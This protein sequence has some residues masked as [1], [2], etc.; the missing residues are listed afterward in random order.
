MVRTP[1][2]DEERQDPDM[3][4]VVGALC[5]MK[6]GNAVK[7]Y[8]SIVKFD[9]TWEYKTDLKPLIPS[10]GPT[11]H[12]EPMSSFLG[13]LSPSEPS[14]NMNPEGIFCVDGSIVRFGAAAGKWTC[15]VKYTGE[16]GEIRYG[17]PLGGPSCPGE[18]HITMQRLLT[19]AQFQRDYPDVTF[20]PPIC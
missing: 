14:F 17:S 9:E 13:G 16:N 15:V 8:L 18:R 2:S 7:K 10:R 6:R 12:V 19:Y 5:K 3:S 1:L 20:H 4:A 11:T